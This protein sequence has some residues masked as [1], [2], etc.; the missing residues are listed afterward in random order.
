MK[1]LPSP[2]LGALYQPAAAGWNDD[3]PTDVVFSFTVTSSLGN[4]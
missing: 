1:P 4:E 2:W 3:T